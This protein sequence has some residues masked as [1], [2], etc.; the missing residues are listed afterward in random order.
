MWQNEGGN[1]SNDAIARLLAMKSGSQ[2]EQELAENEKNSKDAVQAGLNMAPTVGSLK[3]VPNA[4]TESALG[5]LMGQS[6]Y[7]APGL[8]QN[9]AQEGNTAIKQMNIDSVNVPKT[10]DQGFQVTSPDKWKELLEQMASK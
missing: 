7:E 3:M 6:T 8:G 5:K 1:F 10:S 4:A 2:S 9:V